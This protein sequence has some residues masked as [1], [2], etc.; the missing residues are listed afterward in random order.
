MRGTL[1]SQQNAVGCTDIN[2]V[3]NFNCIRAAFNYDFDAKFV[4]SHLNQKFERQY[5][6]VLIAYLNMMY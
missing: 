3:L 4:N 5:F 2:I 6:L 1:T